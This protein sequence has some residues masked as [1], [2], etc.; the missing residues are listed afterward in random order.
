MRGA[1]SRRSPP[2]ETGR[3]SERRPIAR[4][5]APR[6]APHPPLT[7]TSPRGERRTYVRS[8]GSGVTSRSARVAAYAVRSRSSVTMSAGRAS[9][10]LR[11]ASLPSLCAMAPVE[12]TLTSTVHGPLVAVGHG[13]SVAAT[14][15]TA[16]CSRVVPCVLKVIA[17]V[18]AVVDGV[19]VSAH[20]VARTAGSGCTRTAAVHAPAAQ[21]A[22]APM[23]DLPP[24][25][26]RRM[27]TRGHDGT[28]Q[29]VLPL[30][31]VTPTRVPPINGGLTSRE[32][33]VTWRPP[34]HPA[35]G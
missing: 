21:S 11:A 9:I 19:S 24:P 30:V 27:A 16:H 8:H 29:K 33:W 23:N 12:V 28:L 1:Q 14:S 31:F 10:A 25:L 35:R 13:R 2:R 17:A 34:W 7:A 32:L 20:A 18:S 6:P 22:M 15:V 4:R 26:P 3:T 5:R